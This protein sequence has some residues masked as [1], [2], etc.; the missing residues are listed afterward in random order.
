MCNIR[1]QSNT[2]SLH[3]VTQS[4][5]VG[6]CLLIHTQG[7]STIGDICIKKLFRRAKQNEKPIVT[8]VARYVFSA[9]I[10]SFYCMGYFIL[11][12]R[13][14]GFLAEPHTSSSYRS[15]LLNLHGRVKA[16]GQGSD[17][18]IGKLVTLL[19]GTR[20]IQCCEEGKDV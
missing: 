6:N 2:N 11:K 7:N 4:S 9:V 12:Q 13:R 15:L 10:P 8:T 5:K 19:S 3:Y 1:T 17:D 18:G 14:A 20:G 16:L